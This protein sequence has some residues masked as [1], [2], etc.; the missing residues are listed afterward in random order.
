V[1]LQPPAELSRCRLPTRDVNS[2]RATPTCSRYDLDEI[3]S[4]STLSDSAAAKIS[5]TVLAATVPCLLLLDYLDCAECC[6]L[7]ILGSLLV[8]RQ[9]RLYVTRLSV[10]KHHKSW[11]GNATLKFPYT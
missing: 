2:R 7:S 11:V 4:H 5:G 10:R 9:V 8:V 6:E 3:D 1:P